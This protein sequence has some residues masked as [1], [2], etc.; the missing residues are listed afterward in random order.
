MLAIG[1]A[2]IPMAEAFE[3]IAGDALGRGLVVAPAGSVSARLRSQCLSG[4]HPVPD[5]RSERAGRDLLAWLARA[6]PRERLVVLLSG[7]ASSL[8]A[9]P[10]EGVALRDLAGVT[11]HLLAAGAD[12]EELNVVRK[13]LAACA[14]GRLAQR[15]PQSRID[16]LA[17]SDVPMGRL[18]LLGSGPFAADPS[19]YADALAVLDRRGLRAAVPDAARARL[20]AGARGELADTP[21]PGDA[22]L[23]RVHSAVLADVASALAAARVRARELG[24]RASAVTSELRGEARDAGRAIAALA[25]S[26]RPAH[27][28]CLLFGGET[29]VTVRG[30]GRGGRSQELALAA[31]IGLSG[32]SGIALLAAGTDGIDGP[33]RA[34]GAFADGETL[35]RAQRTGV[36]AARALA[37]N[38]SNTFFRV[39]GGLFEPGATGTNVRDLVLVR[40]AG[41]GS[42]RGLRS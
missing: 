1:K 38:D 10:E 3:E 25:C 18:D 14:G 41:D 31:A 6:L 13:H 28:T 11:E 5:E 21:K 29:V 34:A 22:L 8:V 23:A 16:V 19:C 27:S 12:I 17:L 32:T 20:E 37:E 39:E 36:D 35:L 4:S 7:G 40:I 33:T 42:A 15:A 2:A 30:R 24:L 9:C 26:A